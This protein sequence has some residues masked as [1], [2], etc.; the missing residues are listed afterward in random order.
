MNELGLDAWV[1]INSIIDYF[2]SEPFCDLEINGLSVSCSVEK[3][4]ALQENVCVCIYCDDFEVELMYENGINNGTQLNDYSINPTSSLTEVMREY[5]ELIDVVLDED[6]LTEWEFET[7]RKANIEKAR[8]LVDNNKHIIMK[9]LRDQ[10]YDNY[11]TGGG[12]NKAN[13]HYASIRKDL[14]NRCVFWRGVYK[15]HEVKANFI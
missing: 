11:V 9:M 7:G 6:R 5:D 10:S 12:T 13:S 1:K 14:E 3:I 8:I 2:E 4:N 15:T